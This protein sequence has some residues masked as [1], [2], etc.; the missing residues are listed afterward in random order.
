MTTGRLIATGVGLV[1]AILLFV[2]ATSPISGIFL[3]CMIVLMVVNLGD[4]M[5]YRRENAVPKPF[6]WRR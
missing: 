1:F 6:R 2:L 5:T 3:G 4:W